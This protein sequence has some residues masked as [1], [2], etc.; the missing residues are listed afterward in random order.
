MVVTVDYLDAIS[1]ELFHGY[2]LVQLSLRVVPDLLIKS[3]VDYKRTQGTSGP[4]ATIHEDASAFILGRIC[5]TI[6][7]GTNARAE[8]VSLRTYRLNIWGCT[9]KMMFA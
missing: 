1:A 6:F 3:V 9:T 2:R 7:S 4:E 8:I 5:V